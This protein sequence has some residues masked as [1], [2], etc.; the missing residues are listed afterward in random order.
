MTNM[1]EVNNIAKEYTI[2]TEKVRALDGVSFNVNEGEIV[3]LIGR[4][5]GGKSTLLNIL[6]GFEEFDE[7]TIELDGLLVKPDSDKEVF[8]KL[9][10]ITAIHL[11]R[12]FALW[13]EY[14]V[15][16]VLRKI[17]SLRIGYEGLPPKD[18]PEYDEMVEEAM[19]YVRM[20]GLEKKAMHVDY[21]LSGGEKQRVIIARQLAKKPKILL[22]DEPATMACPAT[23]QEILDTLK[24]V[25]S[26]TGLAMLCASHLPEIH[27]YLVDRL[28]WLDGGKIILEGDPEY[29]ISE[30]LK[31]MPDSVPISKIE[32]G[33][34]EIAIKVEDIS[35]RFYLISIG[36]ETLRFN[37]LNFNIN[38]GEI[39][40][41]IGPSGA[42]KTVLWKMLCGFLFPKEGKVLYRQDD[43]WVNMSQYHKKRMAI[44]RRVGLMFQE[45]ALSPH[46][47]IV[48][49]LA[50]KLGVK[51]Q[52]VIEA[53]QE[54]AEELGISEDVLDTI[55]RIVDMPETNAKDEL[56][57][58]GFSPDIFGVLFPRF[59]RTE[60]I[61]YA[62]SIFGALDLSM[63]VLDKYPQELSGGENVRVML[64][65]T[66]APKP[67]I[68]LLD[69][70]FGD[71]DPITLRDVT[72]SLKKINAE[73]GTTILLISHHLDFVREVS[74]HAILIDDGD[75]IMEGEPDVVC[76]EL[77]KRSGALYLQ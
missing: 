59:P 14:V 55:Y 63:D 8:L 38:E 9:K 73:F 58:L 7:G 20:V 17:Y 52:H 36:G 30:F 10:Q 44:R 46:E 47:T 28:I 5:G 27:R 24:K 22:L 50:F 16:D 43:E 19:V 67:D 34:R 2:G 11:Q 18:L 53:A 54:R 57:S 75:F 12:S 56:E 29:V 41:I 51:G 39:T 6:R 45:F 21:V 13:S 76:D 74:H 40:S 65:I 64:A 33:K 25:N 26:E 4:S 35:H 62:E 15:N 61:K 68:L 31:E 23:K 37:S 71:L 69:E 66:L 3:G 60:T 72:N 32:P 70:P 77:V 49:Q 1:L 42:G 48:D